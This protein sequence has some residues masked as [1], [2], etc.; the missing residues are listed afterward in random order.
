MRLGEEVV[1]LGVPGGT[2]RRG[3]CVGIRMREGADG[4]II[5]QYDGAKEDDYGSLAARPSF[6]RVFRVT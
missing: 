2:R 3:A 6:Q 4:V 1:Q 5:S